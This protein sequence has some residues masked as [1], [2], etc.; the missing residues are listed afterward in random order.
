MIRVAC[1]A[2]FAALN[3]SAVPALAVNSDAADIIT[4]SALMDRLAEQ[5]LVPPRP[6]VTLR[7]NGYQPQSDKICARRCEANFV[8]A[9]ESCTA[10]MAKLSPPADASADPKDPGHNICGQS[11]LSGLSICQSEC[12]GAEEAQAITEA[13]PQN[14]TR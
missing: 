7:K 4:A 1:I 9:Y 6:A 14:G 11:A 2:A 13:K 12:S 3:L 10:V 8:K 5:G